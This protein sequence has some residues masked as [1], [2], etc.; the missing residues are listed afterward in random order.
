M[1]S[2]LLCSLLALGMGV[3]AGGGRQAT[4][5]VDSTAP[6][7]LLKTVTTHAE[8]LRFDKKDST[9]FFFR[10]KS[11]QMMLHAAM[12]APEMACFLAN[13][14][15][16]ELLVTYNIYDAAGDRPR[17]YVATR[18]VS[19]KSGDDTRT[20]ADRESKDSALAA[21]HHEELL[22]LRERE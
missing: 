6:A 4:V 13:H 10:D 14:A 16:D 17:S 1:K 8:F 5:P 21:L 2:F 3:R 15:K 20:W 18:I 19:L 12:G 7:R 22:K 11:D 9:Q